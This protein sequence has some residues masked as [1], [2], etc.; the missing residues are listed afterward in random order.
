MLSGEG[1]SRN[2]PSLPIFGKLAVAAGRLMGVTGDPAKLRRASKLYMPVGKR[3]VVIGGGL[4]GTE[5]AEF[6]VERK[7][8]VVVVHD[9]PIFAAEMAHPRRWRVL[10]ELR[11]AG[12]RLVAEAQIEAIGDTAVRVRTTEGTQEVPADTVI[13]ATGLV[14]NPHAIETIRS[15]GVPVVAVGDGNGVGY[16]EGAIQQG[17]EAALA[18]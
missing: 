3:V 16:I 9:G 8:S 6:F 7:R 15:A 18:L 2:G 14:A 17:F 1:A 5:L 10:H 11:E 12:A 4:V 13:L